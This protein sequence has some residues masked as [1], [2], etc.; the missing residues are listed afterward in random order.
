VYTGYITNTGGMGHSG[1][2]QEGNFIVKY[3]QLNL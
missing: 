1:F 3:K 2:I